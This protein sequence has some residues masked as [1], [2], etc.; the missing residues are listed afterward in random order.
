MDPLVL[1]VALSGLVVGA[2]LAAGVA[3]AF[4]GSARRTLA[5]ER[6]E[7][8]RAAVETTVEV[9]RAQVDDAL[10]QGNSE[11]DHR[12]RAFEV[13]VEEIRRTLG[14]VGGMIGALA[15]DKAAQSGQL[16]ERL[17]QVTATQQALASHTDQLRQVLGN[18][19]QRGQWGERMAEDVLAAAGFKRGIQ[20]ERQQAIA[21]GTIPDFTFSLPRGVELR[22]DVKFPIDNYVRV[23]ES[24]TGDERDRYT[25][26]FVRDVR[27]R[28]RELDGRGYID[29]RD[30][31]DCLLLFI[32]NEAVYAFLHEADPEVIDVAMQH[33]V[34][35]CSPSTLFAVLAVI[36]QAAEQFRLEQT[37]DQIRRSLTGLADEWSRFA[38]SLDKLGR[39]FDT[40]HRTLHDE[41]GG[42]RRRV[43]ERSLTEAAALGQ[44]DAADGGAAVPEAAS[45][46]GSTPAS[47]AETGTGRGSGPASGGERLAAQ[48]AAGDV[49][50]L[51]G[52][53]PEV[54]GR[55]S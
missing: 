21:G 12:S 31:V 42:T 35:L 46:S 7:T 36:R 49:R 33:R 25:K 38:E 22:M 47:R 55:A 44:P 23:V 13:Q 17:E 27:N 50:P 26:A 5:A 10:R 52:S 37:S 8:V 19:R 29:A 3:I 16:V 9:A 41:V 18:P 54:D 6:A 53:A 11:L 2:L 34:V 48:L 24:T 32:P 51:P 39:Q 15:R 4:T 28:V 20:Y 40:V 45:P 30:T 14:E 43:F 1:L